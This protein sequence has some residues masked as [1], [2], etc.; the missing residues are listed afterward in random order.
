MEHVLDPAAVYRE[1]WRTL[2]PGGHYIHTFPIE[3]SVVPAITP[4]VRLEEDGSLTHLAPPEYHGNPVSAEGALVTQ[5]Y[6]FEIHKLIASW[7][8]FRVRVIRACDPHAGVLGDYTDVVL[9]TR[10]EGWP[11]GVAGHLTR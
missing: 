2:K 11:E 10:I 4:R 3:R 9:C 7:A 6:G 8:P 1:V 5:R